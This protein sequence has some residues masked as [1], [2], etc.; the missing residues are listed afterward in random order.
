MEQPHA[1]GHGGEG[2]ERK[3]NVPVAPGVELVEISRLKEY[4]FL[5]DCSDIVLR[6]L[7][8]QFMERRFEPGLAPDP[9]QVSQTS[10]RV[11]ST[12]RSVPF[13]TSSKEMTTSVSRS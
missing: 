7:Q 5:K 2:A 4:P 12:S 13:K 8:P 1:A 3:P 10:I 6:K 11:N 9:V